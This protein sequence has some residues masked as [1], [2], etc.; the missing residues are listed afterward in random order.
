MCNMSLQM[1]K[2]AL[3]AA[4]CVT[5]FALAACDSGGPGIDFDSTY[6]NDGSV[7]ENT[8]TESTSS[9]RD[10]APSNNTSSK[11]WENTSEQKKPTASSSKPKYPKGIGVAN[12][13]GFV[14]SPYA[15]YEGLVDVRGFPSGTLVKCP[16]TSKIFV[17]P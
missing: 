14:K 9:S 7:E 5:L 3:S 13:K 17:V 12:K 4:A 6:E 8:P 1:K 15:Q 16:Y 2:L 10:N 11:P